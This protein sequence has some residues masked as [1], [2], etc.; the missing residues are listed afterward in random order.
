MDGRISQK[1]CESWHKISRVNSIRI[2]KSINLIKNF[3]VLGSV[4]KELFFFAQSI[5][6]EVYGSNYHNSF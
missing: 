5:Y 1:I 2:T 6:R 4:V 3:T